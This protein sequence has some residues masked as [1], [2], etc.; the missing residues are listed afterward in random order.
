MLPAAASV[1]PT[2]T[3]EHFDQAVG[4]KLESSRDEENL[5]VVAEESDDYYPEGGIRAWLTVGGAFLMLFCTFGYANAFGMYQ[6]YYKLSLFP[7]QT[8]SNIA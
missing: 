1:L 2:D 5:G 8:A 3:N 7:E 6:S 4:E